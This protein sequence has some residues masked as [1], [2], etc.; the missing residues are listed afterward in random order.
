MNASR[1]Q[2]L[3]LSDTNQSN[4]ISYLSKYLDGA[5][6]VAIPFN[7][8][9]QVMINPNHAV[10]HQHY[11]L[12][13]CWAH[14]KSIYPDFE[15][16]PI[17]KHDMQH[18]KKFFLRLKDK[19]ERVLLTGFETYPDAFYSQ[20]EN[21]QS[22]NRYLLNT[23]ITTLAI[24]NPGAF[25]FLPGH[26]PT[27]ANGLHA[28]SPELW[29]LSKTAWHRTVTDR[30][31]VYIAEIWKQWHGEAIKLVITDLDDTLWGGIVGDEG[32]EQLRL[33]GHDAV[34][35][36][37]VDVQKQLLLW[38]KRGLLLAI[39]SKNDEQTAMQAIDRHPEMQLRRTDF[40]NWKINWD[41]KA[42][43]IQSLLF[44]LNIGAQHTLFIDDN[45]VE[46]SRVAQVFPDMMV[47]A[48]PTNKLA[49]PAFLKTL[50][51]IPAT[52]VLTN[53][54]LMRSELYVAESQRK[55]S[56]SVFADIETWI[57]SLETVVTIEKLS[58]TNLTR[59]AQLLN[60]TNQMNLRTRRMSDEVLWEWSVHPEHLFYTVSVKDKFGDAGLTGL[61]GISI[62]QQTLMVED[63]VL[64][65]RVMGRGIE[66]T[67]LGFVISLIPQNKRSE[68]KF[69][70][71]PTQKN[72]PCREFFMCYTPSSENEWTFRPSDY[73][74]IKGIA[75]MIHDTI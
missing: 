33:G 72:N 39:V 25:S 20:F 67:L 38:K 66:E 68:A 60:K 4:L 50:T 75:C 18:F 26:Y 40:V 73:K 62:Q 12:I 48:I 34:G 14:P 28:A 37:F 53:E 32:W 47:P 46:R 36:S 9:A 55:N 65:C 17:G 42:K 69:S 19:A 2:I 54:D 7:Q 15:K 58:Q 43:N 22:L 11:A 10:W 70:L 45:P 5:E 6:V 57:Q 13:V 63:F 21:V 23:I 49:V 61:I 30:M 27:L 56:A 44:E 41:D 52:G 31:A 1:P 64:S 8:M 51:R 16:A 3:I 71:I 29:Y 35:E 24:E 74:E 59:A